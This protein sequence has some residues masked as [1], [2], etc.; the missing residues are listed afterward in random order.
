MK[1]KIQFLVLLLGL[2]TS[3][4][5]ADIFGAGVGGLI[6]AQMGRGNGRVAMAAV[7]A[8][9]GDRLTNSRV[10]T[11]PLVPTYYQQGYIP[12][13]YYA[14]TAVVVQ[15]PPPPYTA[16]H[17]GSAYYAVS[18]IYRHREYREFHEHHWNA[19]R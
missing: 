11:T 19:Y 9:V 4:A 17:Y 3:L 2:S 15:A 8:V 7:G 18:P 5:H 1:T 12:A 6:G 10:V 14:Q 13:P 16:Y